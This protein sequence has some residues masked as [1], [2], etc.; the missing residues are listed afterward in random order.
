MPLAGDSDAVLFYIS[1]LPN[2]YSTKLRAAIGFMPNV[3]DKWSLISQIMEAASASETSVVNFY[4]STW[5]YIPDG[6]HLRTCCHENLKSQQVVLT[7]ATCRGGPGFR[8][9][10]GDL[11]PD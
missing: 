1:I 2:I 11:Y 3:T 5:C 10:S 4:Q 7:C 8:S 9:Q 6:S